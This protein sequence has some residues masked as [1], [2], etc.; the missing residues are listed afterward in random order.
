MRGLSGYGTAYSRQL[1]GPEFHELTRGTQRAFECDPHKLALGPD[2]Q[3]GKQTLNDTLDQTFRDGQVVT[4]LS[5][6][7]AFQNT[8]E[9][10]PL[11]LIERLFV[12][13][14]S[15]PRR[16]VDELLSQELNDLWVHADSAICNDLDGFQKACG[17][18]AFQEDTRRPSF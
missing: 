15:E 10:I 5:I 17:W 4:D 2:T 14:Q 1:I 3:L 12:A 18:F 7:E 8:K 9:H 16:P 6:G 11:A 13:D